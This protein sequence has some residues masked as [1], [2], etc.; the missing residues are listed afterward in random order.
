MRRIQENM[1]QVDGLRKKFG[2]RVVLR[3]VNF[4]F[5]AD[6]IV[7]LVGPNGAGKTTIM[8]I[9]LGLLTKDAGNVRVSGQ[10]VSAK[11]HT[12]VT[13][14]V[15]ALI[16]HPAIYPFLS[17]RQHLQ[18]VT[19]SDE[20]IT[21]V[22]HALQMAAYIDQ[23]ARRYS[24]G[25]KQ[26][27]GIAMALVGRPRLVILDEPM[28]GLDPQSVK[29]LRDLIVQLARKGTTFL[30]S[31]HILSELEKVIESIILIDQGQ[32]YLQRTMAQL[33]ASARQFL[34]IQTTEN[35]RALQVLSHASYP[36]ML[37]DN[38]LIVTKQVVLTPLLRILLDA[39]IQIS[40]ISQCQEDLETVLLRLLAERRG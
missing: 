27:L 24:L 25:M 22:V 18:L 28:N 30:I 20:Q 1:V 17:G 9:L 29:R 23:P 39:D 13:Q 8:K 14:Q 7:G 16:E 31:S 37:R 40:T 4:S 21:W 5:S 35:T 2:H 32:V 33:R 12:V 10:T 6:E 26:K 34:L 38:D 3:D 11:S 19:N 15:G 36:V